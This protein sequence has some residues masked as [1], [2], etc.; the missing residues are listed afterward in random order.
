M[1]QLLQIAKPEL[2]A[3]SVRNYAKQANK[4]YS[5][6]L[7]MSGDITELHEWIY[8]KKGIS[9]FLSLLA[10]KT[11]KSYISILIT[12]L[13]YMKDTDELNYYIK[14]TQD[15]TKEVNISRKT[16]T[17]KLEEKVISMDEYN[18]L[19]SLSKDEPEYLLFLLLKFLPIRNEIGTLIY[20]TAAD[21]KKITYPEKQHKNFLIVGKSIITV[22][23]FRYK[24]FIKHGPK[25]TPIENKALKAKIRKYIKDNKIASNEPMF[26]FA[27]RPLTENDV[28]HR[29][30][31]VSNKLI[32]I[33]L[34]T[35]SII[36]IVINDTLK[37]LNSLED[38]LT[39]LK[40]VGD[41]RGTEVSTLTDYYIYNKSV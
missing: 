9:D 6:G 3:I 19:L 12:L 7:H 26:T 18:K 40:V 2:S 5:K 4:I 21:Y 38:K 35:S 20:M 14:L 17:S 23:R 1:E 32:G 31:F 37:K 30:S 16:D 10:P 39:Y 29:L 24:T 25:S 27:G 22:D 15:K 28:S 11:Q 36:K 13:K 34:S 41:I 8:N 33:K